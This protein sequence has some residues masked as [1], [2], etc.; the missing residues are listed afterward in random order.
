MRWF[1]FLLAIIVGAALAFFYTWRINPVEYADASLDTLRND[2]KT[3]YVLMVAEIYNQEKDLGDVVRR[4]AQLSL[5]PADE[6]VSQAIF[7]AEKQ[8]YQSE[9]LAQLRILLNNLE[10]Q[11][12][13]SEDQSP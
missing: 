1:F 9:D 4:L 2:Y 13:E 10:A 7:F 8:G 12:P 11:K 5:I 3:D 6:I